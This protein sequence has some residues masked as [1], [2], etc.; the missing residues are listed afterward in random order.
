MLIL[1]ANLGS[2]SFAFAL[3]DMDH[4]GD[5][6]ARGGYERIGQNGSPYKTHAD[7]IEAA[8]LSLPRPPDAIGFKAMH[9]GPISGAVRV[10]AEVMAT[11]ERFADVAPGHNPACVAAMKTLAR[12]LPD[13]PQV[14]TF[15]T[16][17]HQTIPMARQLYA[18]PY[19]WT[20]EWGIR[21]YGF[22]GTSHRY[23][24]LRMAELLPEA[25]RVISCHLGPSSSVCAIESGKSVAN[26]FGMTA[27]SG[28]PQGNSIGDFDTLAL[29]KVAKQGLNLDEILRKLGKE[30]GLLGMSG[31]SA[32]LREIERAAGGNGRAKLTMEAFVEAVRHYIGSSLVAL[33]GCDALAFTGSVGEGGI[34]IREA[35]CRNLDFAGIILDTTKNQVRGKEERISA[36]ESGAEI[37]ILPGNE[38]LIVALQTV[39]VLSAN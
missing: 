10:S 17:F 32:N 25:T 35:I 4:D 11:M 36:V 26:S 5:V 7:A 16:A 20:E 39:A 21:R 15:E 22:H 37:W 6:V 27:H 12:K 1:V 18:I 14:V 9:G 13:A 2:A 8:L 33:G 28:L 34:A 38:D 3:V 30:S 24:A 23:V 19:Q 29:A 31:I